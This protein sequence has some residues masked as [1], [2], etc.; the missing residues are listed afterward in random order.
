MLFDLKPKENMRDFFN[1]TEE[2]NSFVK[3]LTDTSSRM[4]IIRGLRRTGKSSLIRVGLKKTGVRFVL[5]DV[6]EL[7]SL[8]RR[9]FESKLLEELKSIKGLTSALMERIEGLEA[10]VRIS[11]KQEQNVWKLLKQLN[12]VIAIDE[13]QMLRGTGVESFFAAVYDNTNC[14]IV[15][16]G[17]EVGVLD[18]F[19]GKEDPKSPL[20]GRAYK[21]IKM[22]SLTPENSNEFLTLGFKE[23]KKNISKDIIYTALKE[24][25][26]IIGWL[27]MFGNLALSLDPSVALQKAIKTGTK[28][29]YSEFESFLAS[30]AAAKKRYLALGK[31]LVAKDLSWSEL[32][33]ALQVELKESISDPQ[34]TNYLNSLVEYGFVVHV[35][36]AY[37]IPDPL[38][39]RALTDGVSNL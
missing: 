1:Y 30:R 11:L 9:S 39:R 10:G 16:T 24:L 17:S 8:S 20:F 25:D 2:L 34:F 35:G 6:R 18:A 21:E 12:P 7:T 38:L 31:V 3:Y 13:V 37:S 29:A 27:A 19:I 33:L 15:L 14:K 4:I 23:A 36:N 5:I 32:K 22:H 28:L 26:G